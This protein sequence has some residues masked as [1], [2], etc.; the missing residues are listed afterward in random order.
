M[1]EDLHSLIAPYALDALDPAERARFEA[2]LTQCVNCQSELSGFVA[3]AARLG[4]VEGLA[5]PAGLRERLMSE[6]ST[7]RQERP[8]VIALTQSRLRRTLPRLVM[9]AAFLVG[10]VGIGGYVAERDTTND[11]R[12]DRAAITAL[13]SAADATTTDRTFDGGGHVRLVSS[14]EADT[15]YIVATDLPRLDGG[16]VYQVWVVT[17]DSP[18]SEGVFATSG[19]MIMEDIAG[20]DR[21]AVT[22]EPKGGSKQP[23]TAPI[24][25]LAV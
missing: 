9:A 23:T 20:A 22:I 7:T 6:V 3:T 24:A 2:H 12:A 5:P 25:T 17:G 13:M 18:T 15:A 19:E 1:T 8:T 16:K 21:I 14:D 11:L 4:D 10:A